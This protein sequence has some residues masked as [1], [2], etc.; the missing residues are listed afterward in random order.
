M[1]RV[2]RTRP[3]RQPRRG[4]TATELAVILPLLITIVLGCVDFGRFAYTYIAVTNAARAG[5]T[6][7][8]MNPVSPTWQSSVQQV[9]QAE[10]SSQP[11]F[12]SSDWTANVSTPVSLAG[13]TQG[14]TVTASYVFN[15]IVTWNVSGY[16]IPSALTLTQSVT[17]CVIRP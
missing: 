9:A 11:G 6:W 12:Q 7:G 1:R 2:G 8:M 15:T 14:F 10:M 16:G 3:L 5:A 13:G 17:M 4:A